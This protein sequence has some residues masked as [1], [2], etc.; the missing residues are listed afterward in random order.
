MKTSPEED[1]DSAPGLR[2]QVGCAPRSALRSKTAEPLPAA[3]LQRASAPGNRAP[4]APR[5]PRG[6]GTDGARAQS[7]GGAEGAGRRLPMGGRGAGGGRCRRAGGRRCREPAR[8]SGSPGGAGG[9]GGGRRRR[10]SSAAPPPRPPARP[11]ARQSAGRPLQP[12]PAGPGRL[13]PEPG[14]GRVRADGQPRAAAGGEAATPVRAAAR[15]RA[16]AGPGGLRLR[17]AFAARRVPLGSLRVVSWDC[18]EVKG[19]PS[20]APRGLTGGRGA[21]RGSGRQMRPRSRARGGRGA[22]AARSQTYRSAER[23]FP[24]RRREH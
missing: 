4:A 15:S 16:V 22:A 24:S 20:G 6:G 14:A 8:Q 17:G 3:Q 5:A 13:P 10:R 21:G 1:G 2:V 9:A 11:P 12:Q 7:R 19:P 18:P 23:L